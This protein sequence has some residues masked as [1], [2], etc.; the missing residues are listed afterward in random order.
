MI[1]LFGCT[2]TGCKCSLAIHVNTFVA[3][4][5]SLENKEVGYMYFGRY[6]HHKSWLGFFKSQLSFFLATSLEKKD[7]NVINDSNLGT[8]WS[9]IKLQ[10]IRDKFR[11]RCMCVGSFS[12]KI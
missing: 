2:Y 1:F 9:Y 6:Q 3:Q 10:Q 11:C 5:I 4:K 12:T 8:G 7:T